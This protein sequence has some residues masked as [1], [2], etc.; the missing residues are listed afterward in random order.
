MSVRK[1]MRKK[2]QEKKRFAGKRVI[3]TQEGS[4]AAKHENYGALGRRWKNRQRAEARI[5]KAELRG[6]IGPLEHKRIQYLNQT[7]GKKFKVPVMEGEKVVGEKFSKA[8]L[9]EAFKQHHITGEIILPKVFE[10]IPL[11]MAMRRAFASKAKKLLLKK[12]PT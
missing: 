5:M 9:K 11:E 7:I 1:S 3:S 2:R 4:S 6:Q 12:T 8:L 10:K